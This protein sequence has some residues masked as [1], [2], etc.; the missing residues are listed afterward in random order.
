MAAASVFFNFVG[1][2]YCPPNETLF[3]PWHEG[4]LSRCFIWTFSTFLSIG[5]SFVALITYVTCL[6]R[7]SRRSE[8]NPKSLGYRLQVVF[9]V[10]LILITLA[11]AFI[12]MN[13]RSSSGFVILYAVGMPIS[14]TIAMSLLIIERRRICPRLYGMRH[15][16]PLLLFWTVNFILV[17]LPLTS[18]GGSSWWWKLEE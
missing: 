2:L 10:L 9:S 3:H 11:H 15:G 1:M 4:E 7:N 6:C 17:N 5:I 18:I 14:W 16:F 13:A 8:N 12:Y